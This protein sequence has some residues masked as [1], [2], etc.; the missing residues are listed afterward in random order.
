MFPIPVP[1]SWLCQL[2]PFWLSLK[3]LYLLICWIILG[4][5]QFPHK[6]RCW[7]VWGCG[8]EIIWWFPCCW[9]PLAKSKAWLEHQQEVNYDTSVGKRMMRGQ[10]GGGVTGWHELF[11]WWCRTKVCA[12]GHLNL[13]TH[14]GKGNAWGQGLLKLALNALE[15]LLS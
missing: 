1:P 12:V 5:N 4:T 7:A 3:S 2:N 14:P 10:G 9:R 13:I 15:T 6:L 11:F 8:S